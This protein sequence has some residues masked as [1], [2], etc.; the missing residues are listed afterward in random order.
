M[1]ERHTARM[2]E[3]TNSYKFLV[4]K[5]DGKRYPGRPRDSLEGNCKMY[6]RETR[7]VKVKCGLDSTVSR[8][9]SD[10]PL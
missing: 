4:G 8:G 2:G 5:P 3:T 6:F 7:V 1:W 9:I 10:G